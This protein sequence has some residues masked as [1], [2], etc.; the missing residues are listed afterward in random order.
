MSK[1][2]I[3]FESLRKALAGNL[4]GHL[5]QIGS[6]LLSAVVLARTLGPE[7][8]GIVAIVSAAVRMA[9]VPAKEGANKLSER[10]LAG[11]IGKSDGAQARAAVR[12]NFLVS[13]AILVLGLLAIYLF[14]SGSAIG[15]NVEQA[16]EIVV[17]GLCLFAVTITSSAF[18]GLLRGEGQTVRAVNLTNLTTI[19]APFSFLVWIWSV[20]PLTPSTALFL[21]V[22][23]KLAVLP[24]V[25]FLVWRYWAIVPT[26]DP[27]R[28]V[29]PIPLGWYTESVQFTLLGIVAIALM[30]VATLTLSYLSTPAEAGLFRIASRVFLVA[31]FVTM[32]AQSA[33]G[34]RI[35]HTWQSGNAA[36]LEAPSRM[37]SVLALA[38]SL[39]FLLTFAAFGRW[40][41]V[42]AFGP[43]FSSAFVPALIM[44]AAAVSVSFSAVSPRLLKMT[45]E[46]RVVLWGSL[47]GL[48]VAIGLNFLLIPSYG[49]TGCALSML[50]AL[51]LARAI[52][53]FGV[54]KHLGFEPLPNFASAQALLTKMRPVSR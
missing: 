44:S 18:K 26:V 25:V 19:M 22:A 46:Q 43:E 47:A 54:R 9:L 6:L 39:T 23:T 42:L 48:V 34:P 21:Q 1:R 53:S 30:E 36:A 27:A 12:L 52:F 35:A 3:A 14:L 7:G 2:P 49:A 24:L 5:I 17:A 15:Q 40:F 13:F 41:L 31:G 33:Y 16:R 29:M 4:F 32:A 50:V 10:E 38:G 45:G 28:K 8:L 51:T 11:A 20:G 37:I